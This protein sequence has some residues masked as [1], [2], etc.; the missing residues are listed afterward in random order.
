M[1]LCTLPVGRVQVLPFPYLL[2]I[3]RGGGLLTKL[4]SF[5]GEVS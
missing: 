2:F 4:Y 1:R 3:E 5:L